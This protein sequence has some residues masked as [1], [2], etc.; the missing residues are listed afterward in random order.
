[1]RSA[2]TSDLSCLEENCVADVPHSAQD[3]SQSHACSMFIYHITFI[4]YI[5]I[6][7]FKF[8][9]FTEMYSCFVLVFFTWKNVSIV[10]LT[11]SEDSAITE[12]HRAEWT[13]TRKQT[14]ALRV[15]G[16]IHYT[17]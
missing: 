5:F 8:I 3:H 17:M 9:I 4:I 1:M 16:F 6:Y 2:M 12:S 13:A 7:T 10:P 15:L 14:P 11:R